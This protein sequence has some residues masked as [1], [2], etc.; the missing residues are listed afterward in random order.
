MLNSL[1]IERYLKELGFRQDSDNERING[2]FHDGFKNPLYV[3]TPSKN[4]KSNFVAKNP[5]VIHSQYESQKQSLSEIKGID[6]DWDNYY[7]NSNMKGFDK[8]S[9]SRSYH[10]IALNIE[11]EG[12]L[13]N[14]VSWLSGSFLPA[15]PSASEHE[16]IENV[17]EELNKA[18]ETTREI[19]VQ[20]RKGQGPYKD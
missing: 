15:K 7:L 16:D 10:G 5:L 14:F 6:P 17:K 9:K 1:E 3:K 20:A 13:K 2:F 4:S 11:N 8:P 18:P 12:A 19:L